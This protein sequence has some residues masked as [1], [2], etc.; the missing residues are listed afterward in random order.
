MVYRMITRPVSPLKY[1]KCLD[2]KK[3]GTG[4]KCLEDDRG[5]EEAR[6]KSGGDSAVEVAPQFPSFHS[7]PREPSLQPITARQWPDGLP[8]VPP[9]CAAY[10][11]R[12]VQKVLTVA[13]S[14]LLSKAN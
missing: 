10:S 7:S 12:A 11:L 4:H 13:F 3:R 1:A 6:R 5:E 9:R 14:L 8:G 2:S